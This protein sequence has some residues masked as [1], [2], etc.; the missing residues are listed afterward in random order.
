MEDARTFIN[1]WT[2]FKSHVLDIISKH[3]PS[4]ILSNILIL[5]WLTPQLP[6]VINKN[7]KLSFKARRTK[8]AE[9][10]AKYKV[11]K[12]ETQNSLWKAEW[13]ATNEHLSLTK[14]HYILVVKLRHYIK[15]TIWVVVN[16]RGWYYQHPRP[17]RWPIAGYTTAAHWRTWHAQTTHTAQGKQ[18][19]WP[20]R[21]C[22]T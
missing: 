9:L 21:V 4:K 6:K 14:T 7:N 19:F 13:M 16:H 5:R 3:V 22:P 15:L 1:N 20:G 2:R 12:R 11:C 17:G 10:R 8:Q 18:S